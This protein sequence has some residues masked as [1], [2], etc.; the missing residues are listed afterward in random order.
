MFSGFVQIINFCIIYCFYQ[1]FFSKKKYILRAKNVE[2]D[3]H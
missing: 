2:K 3:Q 1:Y